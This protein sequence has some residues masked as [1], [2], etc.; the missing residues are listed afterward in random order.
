MIGNE[1]RATSQKEMHREHKLSPCA[2]V[3][4]MSFSMLSVNAISSKHFP[5][6]DILSIYR[7]ST[8]TLDATSAIK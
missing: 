5:V 1:D 8:L 6:L 4:L 2:R 3:N 7:S